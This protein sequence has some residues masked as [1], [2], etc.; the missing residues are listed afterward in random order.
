MAVSIL[1]LLP[2]PLLREIRVGVES[3]SYL[4]LE[5]EGKAFVILPPDGSPTKLLY[6]SN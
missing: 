5:L 2:P 4:Q 6:Q 1:A 3:E